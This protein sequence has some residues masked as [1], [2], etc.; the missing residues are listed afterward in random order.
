M[1]RT[2]FAARKKNVT[3]N[4][5]MHSTGSTLILISQKVI[6]PVEKQKMIIC[7]SLRTIRCYCLMRSFQVVEIFP[8]NSL[9]LKT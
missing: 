9:D 1:N 3:N 8:S 6:K 7:D 4:N 5:I 2:F